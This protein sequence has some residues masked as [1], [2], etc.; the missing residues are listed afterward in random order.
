MC[1]NPTAVC[2]TGEVRR[3]AAKKKIDLAGAASIAIL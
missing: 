3:T 1:A 2:P